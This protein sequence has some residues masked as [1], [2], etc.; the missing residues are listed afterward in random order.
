MDGYM[1]TPE[2][3]DGK[4]YVSWCDG[5][6]WLYCPYCGKKQFPLLP[7]TQIKHLLFKCKNSKC[8]NEFMI[9]VTE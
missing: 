7:S 1:N 9:D 4:A 3:S 6:R 2:E 8:K 5:E